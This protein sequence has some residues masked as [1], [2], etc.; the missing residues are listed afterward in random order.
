MS[1]PADIHHGWLPTAVSENWRHIR[2]GDDPRWEYCPNCKCEQGHT[3]DC[4]WGNDA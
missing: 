1:S 3:D 2:V 4:G